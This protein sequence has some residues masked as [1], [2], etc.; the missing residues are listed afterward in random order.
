MAASPFGPMPRI[1]TRFEPFMGLTSSMSSLSKGNALS[2]AEPAG[3][4]QRK[5]RQSAPNHIDRRNAP[6]QERVM[7]NS[8]PSTG[9]A[10]KRAARRQDGPSQISPEAGKPGND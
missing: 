10:T 1:G 4:T 6:E 5:P 9:T 2:A 8:N 3:I 7:E